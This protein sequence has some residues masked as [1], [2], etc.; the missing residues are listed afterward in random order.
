MNANVFDEEWF[1]TAPRREQRLVG[2]RGFE[3]V[4]ET[5]SVIEVTTRCHYLW[6]IDTIP[7]ND[8]LVLPVF[9]CKHRASKRVTR[10]KTHFF[11]LD[12]LV[13]ESV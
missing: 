9:T 2:D 13:L 6:P 11:I 5:A 4:D 1:V 8:T 3:E 7:T 10:K 12:I